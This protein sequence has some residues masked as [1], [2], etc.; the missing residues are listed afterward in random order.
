MTYSSKDFYVFGLDEN[1]KKTNHES[2]KYLNM[3]SL[4]NQRFQ[5]EDQKLITKYATKFNLLG[6]KS[7]LKKSI[8]L[9]ELYRRN[10]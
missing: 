4:V 1:I 3:K 10:K 2:D 6:D 7:T 8:N 5:E 9:K